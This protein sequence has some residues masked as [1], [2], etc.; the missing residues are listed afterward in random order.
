LVQI[1]RARVSDAHQPDPA[2]GDDR[3]KEKKWGEVERVQLKPK[4]GLNRLSARQCTINGAFLILWRKGL[5]GGGLELHHPRIFGRALVIKDSAGKPERMLG[6]NLDVSEKKQ[7]ERTKNLLAAVVDSSDDAIV[8]KTLDGTITSWNQGAERIF[9]YTAEEAVGQKILII[10]PEDRRDEENEILRRLRNGERIDH[11][12]TVR[13]KKDG[14]LVNVSVTISPIKDATGKIIGAS[15]VGRD[16]SQRKRSDMLL[17]ESEQRFRKLSESL[18]IEVRNRTLELEERNR[19]I[20][21]H[22]DHV[23][24]LS[25]E[26]LRA[27]DKERRHIARELH[28]SAGQTLAVLGMNMAAILH[29]VL[30]KS[31]DVISSIEKAQEMIQ[32][33][34][35]DIRTTSYLL[36]PPLLDENGLPAALSWYVRGLSERSGIDVSLTISEEFGRLPSDMELLIFRLVQECLTNVHRH[37]GSRNAV[38]EV[39]RSSDR[40]SLEVRDQGKGISPERLA[41]INSGTSGVGIRGMRE[42]LREFGGDLIIDSEGMGTTV[43]VTMPLS[44]TR[45]RN[46]PASK[47][48]ESAI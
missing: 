10:I 45:T 37:S 48:V 38:I 16:I 4:S 8:S 29:K 3:G 30:T 11:F 15:K 25:W 39:S 44:N 32:E 22:A 35:K 40:I 21:L 47:G 13:R 6:I 28:D 43:F 17:Q 9:G 1:Q 12:E 7:A 26:L 19:E 46:E 36:H 27:Q 34:T 31:P 42:R 20:L 14:S 41:Q 23:R 2:E 24:Q 5:R 18:E 33:L